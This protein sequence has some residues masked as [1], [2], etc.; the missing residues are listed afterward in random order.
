MSKILPA[1]NPLVSVPYGPTV[2]VDQL[3]LPDASVL[4]YPSDKS[5]K[6]RLTAF[7]DEISLFFEHL[8]YVILVP[9][10]WF[11]TMQHFIRV[12][13]WR[14][15]TLPWRIAINF[16]ERRVRAALPWLPSIW[17]MLIA[18]FPNGIQLPTFTSIT[19]G[20]YKG[21][22][23]IGKNP[24]LPVDLDAIIRGEDPGTGDGDSNGGPPN[25]DAGQDNSS[26]LEEA[27]N[28]IPATAPSGLDSAL[29]NVKDA[30]KTAVQSLKS[31]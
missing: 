29:K 28:A 15:L 12:I 5:L 9:F 31:S 18:L 30:Q 7:R 8:K 27:L 22:G 3:H 17:G 1:G 16:Y 13:I 26:P 19:A 10:S 21:A 11:L 14:F 2:P 4:F 25:G 20:P 23:P 6:A 24:T